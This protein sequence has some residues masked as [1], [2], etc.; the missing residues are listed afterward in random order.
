VKPAIVDILKAVRLEETVGKKFGAGV[1]LYDGEA[2]VRF[3]EQLF[4][5]PVSQSWTGT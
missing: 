3:G 4:K 1:V 2:I 5:M